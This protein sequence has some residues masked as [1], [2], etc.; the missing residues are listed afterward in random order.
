[1]EHASTEEK[2]HTAVELIRCLPKTGFIQPSNDLRLKFYS[3]Y[4]Q[5]VD[6]P[7]ELPKPG[8]WDVVNR[9]KWDA[10]NKLGNMSKEEAM[11]K[12]VDEF[13][14]IIKETELDDLSCLS[15]YMHLIGPY[16][17]FV[18][19]EIQE[20]HNL[21]NGKNNNIL[22]K[23]PEEIA[24]RSLNS[25][26]PLKGFK[27]EYDDDSSEDMI[28][29]SVN[30]HNM[31]GSNESDSEEFS[32]TLERVNE[33]DS[34]ETS[35]SLGNVV[36]KNPVADIKG[37]NVSYVRGGGEQPSGG[38]DGN[39]AVGIPSSS[40]GSRSSRQGRSSDNPLP[41]GSNN[42]TSGGAGGSRRSGG[43]LNPELTADVN[44]QLAL[45]VLRLQHIMEQVVVRLDSL[46]ALL[47][48]RKADSSIL[49]VST[50]KQSS[51]TFL[52]ISPKLA[53]IILA[54]PFIVQWL[55]YTIRKRRFRS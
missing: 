24:E 22:K 8:F 38:R 25:G 43:N 47:T 31:N 4:K 35:V 10:W 42:S 17:D 36:A 9:A 19:K 11:Q 7:C 16:I 37:S 52:G 26:K 44:E 13:V 29:S 3:Y 27:K 33:N 15:D 30:G 55:M 2:F 23:S 12:Y 20:Q 54:W 28:L 46:E 39:S 48:Q 34:V 32:D 6:G 5:A 53:V 50:G 40:R 41:Y 14:K 18:P 51:W 45:A 1:M 49:K 21:M